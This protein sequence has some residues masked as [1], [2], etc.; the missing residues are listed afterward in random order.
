MHLVDYVQIVLNIEVAEM[1]DPKLK[2]LKN[3]LRQAGVRVSQA[4]NELEL[5][6]ALM[7]ENKAIAA[8]IVHVNEHAQSPWI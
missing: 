2:A 7:A 5:K 3:D 8:L 1:R 6:Q 4:G